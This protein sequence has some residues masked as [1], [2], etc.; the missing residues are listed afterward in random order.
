MLTNHNNNHAQT[1]QPPREN[2]LEDIQNITKLHTPIQVHNHHTHAGTTRTTNITQN[3]PG[4]NEVH[5]PQIQQHNP[6]HHLH[7]NKKNNPYPTYPKQKQTLTLTTQQKQTNKSNTNTNQHPPNNI[8]TNLPSI[9]QIIQNHTTHIKPNNYNHTHNHKQQIKPQIPNQQHKHQQNLN[10]T[11]QKQITPHPTPNQPQHQPK[12]IT[13]P[14]N[15]HIHTINNQQ[16]QKNITTHTNNQPNHLQQST[17]IILTLTNY[18]HNNHNNNPKQPQTHP[19]I[20]LP[21]SISNILTIS[22]H[23]NHN[24]NIYTNPIINNPH[25]KLNNI[26]K[27]I[28]PLN[29][30]HIQIPN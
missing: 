2:Q 30:L 18:K 29:Y 28:Q 27:N 13:T 21:T 25:I 6:I 11:K 22:I 14:T 3:S 1:Y 7:V 20:T 15:K 9:K 23:N 5:Q 19:T 26:H 12:I 4:T 16:I 17:N 10:I 24:T 8:N